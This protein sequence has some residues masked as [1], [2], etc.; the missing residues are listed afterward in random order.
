MDPT[1]LLHDIA[2]YANGFFDFLVAI[3]IIVVALTAVR[4]ADATLGYILTGAMSVRFLTL[5]CT[6]AGYGAR[7]ALSEGGEV[8]SMALGFL[9]L[10][11]AFLELGLWIA[12]AYC[13]YTL[14]NK[15]APQA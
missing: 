14:A 5:C 12:V 3:A 13:L 1:S 7:D 4:K 9:S 11:G 8:L 2:Y 6:R 15:V 10:V